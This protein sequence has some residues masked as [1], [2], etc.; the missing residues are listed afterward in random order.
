MPRPFTDITLAISNN[1]IK[2][3]QL[4]YPPQQQVEQMC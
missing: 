3:A 2:T 4:F 1:P